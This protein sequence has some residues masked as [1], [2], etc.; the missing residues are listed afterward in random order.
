MVINHDQKFRLSANG[1]NCLDVLV[2]EIKIGEVRVESGMIPHA[3]IILSDSIE[4]DSQW[5]HDVGEA[6]ISRT[7]DP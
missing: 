3:F 6:A 2:A 5:L 7:C 4:A 1:M